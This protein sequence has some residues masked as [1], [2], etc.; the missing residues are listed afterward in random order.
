MNYCGGLFF[1]SAA[2]LLGAT[3]S[4]DLYTVLA[5]A[6][7]AAAAGLSAVKKTLWGAIV[8]GLIVAVSLGLQTILTYRCIDCIIADLLV[9]AG[10][11]YL[12]IIDE[13]RMR[14]A[15]RI[16][17]SVIAVV[18]AVNVA[19]H[20]PGVGTGRAAAAEKIYRYVSATVNGTEV[21]LDTQVRPVLLFS[22]TCGPCRETVAEL[23]VI[24]PEG[25]EWVPVLANGNIKEGSKY[26]MEVG[27]SGS[28]YQ[29]RWGGAV[30]ALLITEDGQTLE[31]H[32]VEEILKAV[33]GDSG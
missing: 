29:R 21:T 31:I 27:Y 19:L 13:S 23:S 10:V 2:I 28:V 30:P 8:G 26:L 12:S 4:P 24:D 9:L 33:R 5:V 20:Y 14:R 11:I 1:I 3:K 22:P 25:S 17:A 7:C 32:G 16:M 15:L 6:A 18:L